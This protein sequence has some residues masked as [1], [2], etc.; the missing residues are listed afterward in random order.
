[1][2]QGQGPGT[3]CPSSS[4]VSLPARCVTSLSGQWREVR[5]EAPSPQIWMLY[6]TNGGVWEGGGQWCWHFSGLEGGT[7]AMD[8]A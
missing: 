3:W 2:E 1:M 6:A 5:A 7:G 8:A 4:Q